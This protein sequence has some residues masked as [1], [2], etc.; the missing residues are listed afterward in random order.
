MLYITVR[1]TQLHSNSLELCFTKYFRLKKD[2]L[3]A[4][5]VVQWLRIHLAMQET[6]RDKGLIPGQGTEIPHGTGQ[7][8]PH[9]PQLLSQHAPVKDPT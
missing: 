5:L 4:S 1:L 8:S 7:L 2:R 3:G 6:A 9:V